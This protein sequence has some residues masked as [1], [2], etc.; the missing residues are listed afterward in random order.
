MNE[1]GKLRKEYILLLQ[2]GELEMMLGKM[3][4]NCGTHENIEYHHI[5]PLHLGGTN[6]FSNITPL[7][8]RCHEAAHRGQHISRYKNKT[9]VGGRPSN[10]S[11]KDAFKALDMWADGQIGNRKCFELMKRAHSSTGGSTISNSPQYKRWIKDRGY[12]R[13]KN[14]IDVAATRAIGGFSNNKIVGFIEYEDERRVYIHFHDTCA[15][16]DVV[17]KRCGKDKHDT[18]KNIKRSSYGCEDSPFN[19]DAS[20]QFSFA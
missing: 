18:F 3:C 10:V 13:V 4:S 17:Y 14:N 5:V 12:K 11:D 8:H 2:G 16:D 15:N 7:C 9:R 6:R 20:G 1:K 19:L